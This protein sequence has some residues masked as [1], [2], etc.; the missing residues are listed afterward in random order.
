MIQARDDAQV[1][2]VTPADNAGVKEGIVPLL[3]AR[4]NS[5]LVQL[6]EFQKPS[7][8]DSLV[9]QRSSK[10]RLMH[11][12]QTTCKMAQ[13]YLRPPA[14]PSSGSGGELAHQTAAAG[15][16]SNAPVSVDGKLNLSVLSIAQLSAL[17]ADA[18]GLKPGES[19]LLLSV[20]RLMELASDDSG[21]RDAA[22]QG[23]A[24]V[25]AEALATDPVPFAARW[26]GSEARGPSSI[27]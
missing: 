21:L 1:A 12:V 14:Y 23:L 13:R 25:L 16:A 8:L 27:L 4:C 24:G 22:M 9:L 26:V 20:L 5:L 18:W 10:L 15:S 17:Q 3:L 6:S 19:Q 7:L 2:T 11:F